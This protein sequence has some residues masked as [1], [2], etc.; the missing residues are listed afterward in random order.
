[1]K[2]K[3]YKLGEILK[4]ILIFCGFIILLPI[5]YLTR[6]TQEDQKYRLEIRANLDLLHKEG[7]V[8]NKFMNDGTGKYKPA[9][10]ANKYNFIAGEYINSKY[11]KNKLI[12]L[13]N[14]IQKR[15]WTEVSQKGYMMDNTLTENTR[16]FCKNGASIVIFMNDLSLDNDIRASNNTKTL[17]NITYSNELPCYYLNKKQTDKTNQK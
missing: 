15:G 4:Y 6:D 12:D 9:Y 13:T 3:L 14:Y 8:I 2:E 10:F 16:T 17:I 11:D 1:M 5:F 7:E